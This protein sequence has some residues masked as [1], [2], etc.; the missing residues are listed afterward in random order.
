[1]EN[2]DRLYELLRMSH[3]GILKEFGVPKDKYKFINK[4]SSVCL[5]CHLDT[6][7]DGRETDIII[8]DSSI[9]PAG[10]HVL[11][12]DDRVGVWMCEE[13]SNKLGVSVLYTDN[14]ERG[15]TGAFEF[16]KVHKDDLQDIKL[17]IEIDRHG[18]MEYVSYAKNSYDVHNL[19]NR[20][21]LKRET[22]LFSDVA[23][24][25]RFTGIEH[26]N[27][28]C[29]YYNEHTPQEMIVI[30]EMM[31]MKKVIENIIIDAKDLYASV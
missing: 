17:F 4:R 3:R 21:G 11:G 19:M 9:R 31:Q 25:T 12:A 14:E 5:V 26:V 10:N 28:A 13:L 24:I 18:F 1:M 20:H 16:C 30:T 6:V 27:I 2:L 7:G 22:G 15:A 8:R 29:G 23:V